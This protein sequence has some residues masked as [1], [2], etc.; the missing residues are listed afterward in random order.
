MPEGIVLY[1]I[2]LKDYPDDIEFRTL[3]VHTCLTCGSRTN[4]AINTGWPGT[5]LAPCCQ[6]ILKEW[7]K[8]VAKLKNRL[9]KI[10]DNSERLPLVAEIERILNDNKDELSDDIK[11]DANWSL[12]W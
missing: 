1:D 2:R 10:N 3:Q 6:N 12:T 7:H 8:E 4:K 9:K 11:G 5:Y